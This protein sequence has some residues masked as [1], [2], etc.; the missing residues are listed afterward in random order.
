MDLPWAGMAS[1]TNGEMAASAP[2]SLCPETRYGVDD[3]WTPFA[4]GHLDTS[5]GRFPDAITTLI[6]E[7][8][9]QQFPAEG[10]HRAVLPEP[11]ISRLSKPRSG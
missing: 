3:R 8:R 4:R 1:A 11:D 5:T 2:V 7:E 10:V 6:D 9:R